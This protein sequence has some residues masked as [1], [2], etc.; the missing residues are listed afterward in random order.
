MK[1]NPAHSR[2]TIRLKGHTYLPPCQVVY[3]D[4]TD[5]ARYRAYAVGHAHQNTGVAWRNVQ[6]IDVVTGYG[7]PAEGNTE[8]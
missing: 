3:R 5:Q 8:R 2:I 1:C 6:M 7:E 4:W